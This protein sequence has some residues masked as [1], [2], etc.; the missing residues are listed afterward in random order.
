[1]GLAGGLFGLCAVGLRP[2]AVGVEIGATADTGPGAGRL[3]GLPFIED[4]YAQALGEARRTN[5]P[6]FV[7][8]WAPWC[9]TCLSLRAFVFGDPALAPLRGR[10]VWASIDTEKPANA[11]FVDAHPIDAWPTL[12]VVDERTGKTRRLYRGA[13]RASE[14]AT[15][16][17][18]AVGESTGGAPAASLRPAARERALEEGVSALRRRGDHPRFVRDGEA[19]LR[20]LPPGTAYLNVAAEGLTCA[21]LLARRAAPDSTREAAVA[22]FASA[23]EAAVDDDAF[24]VLADDRSSGFE[25][26]V[27]AAQA[28]GDEPRVRR[29]AGRWWSFLDRAAGLAPSPVARAVFDA[30]RTEAALALQRPGLAVAALE[31][32]ARDFP[33]DYNPPAR[34]A[35][36]YLSAGRVADARASIDRAL[37]LVY[38]PRRQRLE[39][40]S[41][42]IAAAEPEAAGPTGRPR[43][44]PRS[45]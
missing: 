15:L 2:E 27:S 13:L 45:R 42:Q 31:A 44:D 8:A 32:S 17:L 3:A 11:P 41:K 33:T 28:S 20:A 7:D 16:L 5:R 22:V 34:L 24:P 18:D 26:L 35:R 19:A 10:F 14:L 30:H 12:F 6:L 40:L 9:H 21:T 38:G 4:D 23:L 25:A 39:A 37:G 1:M 43:P 29:L 36:L